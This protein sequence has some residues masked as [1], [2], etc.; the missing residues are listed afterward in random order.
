MPN[1]RADIQGLRAVAVLLVIAEHA[2]TGLSGGFVGVDI[3]FV[4]SG[5]VIT[6]ML[7]REL[8][9]HGRVRLSRFYIRRAYRLIP[10]A[11]LVLV[12]TAV[13]G[14][15]LLSPLG[16]QQQAAATGGAA[17]VGLSNIALYVINSD[18][19]SEHV[20]SNPFLHTWSLGVEEQFYFLFPLLI[21][22]TWLIMRRRKVWLW[23]M[24]ALV[25]A[26]SFSLSA[27]M[28]FSAVI[29]GVQN[30]A[31]FAFYMMPTRAWEFGVGALIALGASW[32]SNRGWH[33]TSGWL[34]L[35]LIGGSAVFVDHSM[36]FP[37][38][39]AIAP[40]L[41]TALI[42]YSGLSS[43][44]GNALL[45]AKPLVHLGDLSYSLYLWHWPLLVF[46]RRLWPDSAVAVVLA[47][48]LTYGAAYLTFRYVETPMR[49]RVSRVSWSTLR[50]PIIAVAASLA[51]TG[52]MLVG[53]QLNWGNGNVASAADQLLERPVGYNDCLSTTP[54]SQRDLTECTW[55][56]VGDR[57]I[58]LVGDSNAQQYTEA[59]IG[60]AT[61]LQRP[62]TV[63]TW[64]GCPFFDA[65]RV[66]ADN[67]SKGAECAVYAQDG[68]DWISYQ[69]VGTVVMA[70]AGAPINGVDTQL[71]AVDGS[72]LISAA[73]KAQRWADAMESRIRELE[74]FGHEVL[75]VRAVPHFAGE[76]REWWHPVECQ[77]AAL[78]ADP[79]TCGSSV[80]DAEMQESM[81]VIQAAEATAIEATGAE[82]LD[83][84][85]M[86]CE[87]GLCQ[88][89]RDGDW[90]YRD[91]LH[92]SPSYSGHLAPT[93]AAVLAGQR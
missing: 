4:I 92:L 59:L 44:A 75:V 86:I 76:N 62:L 66:D 27:W 46:S 21:S 39:V 48:L 87:D 7:Y 51:M 43:N 79:V 26:A 6:A 69:P 58:Y 85:A 89:Y 18:Y 63:A 47:V 64:G 53:A 80:P 31:M 16:T 22:L 14:M 25:C 32:L 11:A 24:L 35:A 17:A 34:G 2:R 37:G 15:L 28:S 33:G 68:L 52:G 65:G 10:A 93:F 57:P 56:A 54:V 72:P 73:D 55:P 50:A 8:Q 30:P 83:L 71:T 40:V 36:P 23:L 29:P 88:T 81:R 78:F 3:F 60:A 77:N 9:Q 41:G 19:F 5:F 61:Q 91:G 90:I 70:S 13:L 1:F 49:G 74:S 45:S 82:S 42:L 67:P 38:L 20:Q 12:V 84:T